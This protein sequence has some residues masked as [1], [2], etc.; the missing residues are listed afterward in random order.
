MRLIF[1]VVTAF[2][3]AMAGPAAAQNYDPNYPV[4]IQYFGGRIGGGGGYIACK[5]TSIP[6]CQATA[7]GLA[8]T[9]SVNPYYAGSRPAPGRRHRHSY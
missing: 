9:C 8:A 7:S 2:T 1:Y 3:V 5:F 4:C 6:Q